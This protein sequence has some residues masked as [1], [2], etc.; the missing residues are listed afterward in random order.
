MKKEIHRKFSAQKIA[1]IILL[2][3]TI[4]FLLFYPYHESLW[5]GLI[6]SFASAGL[7][8]GIADWFAIKS[9]FTKPLGISWP[10]ALFKTEMIPR[11]REQV[12]SVIVDII[13]D[14]IITKDA[15]TE[16]IKKIEISKLLI[17]YVVEH[18]ILNSVAKD[19]IAKTNIYSTENNQTHFKK[20]V[21]QSINQNKD[22]IYN[23]SNHLAD[24]SISN[25]YVHSI[26]NSAAV[27]L[28]KLLKLP[29]VSSKLNELFS[30]IKIRYN[31]GNNT[32]NK[33]ATY[34]FSTFNNIPKELILLADNNLEL[35]K[36]P[37]FIKNHDLS[38]HI[39]RFAKY[40]ALS[41]LLNFI[42][43]T[44]FK[45]IY[46]EVATTNLEDATP[47]NK[48]RSM[49]YNSIDKLNTTLKENTPLRKKLITELDIIL[50]EFFYEKIEYI[51]KNKLAEYSNEML[52][53][54]IYNS[55]GDDLNMIRINGSL[56]GGMVGIIT[57][58]I[59]YI[60]R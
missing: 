14:K 58:I 57:F 46:D 37:E 27:E 51:I 18:R 16:K 5:G 19:I 56:I 40:S 59:M 1:N 49:V 26:L 54:E 31:S 44:D 25:G 24:W 38:K 32:L 29:V 34:I 47:S 35:V 53:E 17:D 33:V 9:F 6:F 42:K 10:K 15:L 41:S 43:T 39:Q 55:V 20:L 60:A 7:I 13:Q 45:A 2:I 23:A 36:D 30:N 12:I 3:F 21:M 22:E 48:A 8:G 50:S 28:Q 11:N 52:T 4:M